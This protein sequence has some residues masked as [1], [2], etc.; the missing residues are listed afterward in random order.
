MINAF[1]ITWL[2][3]C[4]LPLSWIA[5]LW[6]PLSHF[7]SD[8]Q[9][10]LT[11]VTW[12]SCFIYCASSSFALPKKPLQKSPAF[13]SHLLYLSIPFPTPNVLFLITLSRSDS[14]ST[15]VCFAGTENSNSYEEV[16][17]SRFHFILVYVEVGERLP[18]L[19]L[20]PINHRHMLWETVIWYNNCSCKNYLSKVLVL[21]KFDM[22]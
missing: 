5:C 21:Y 2:R 11:D 20:V 17:G 8:P 7:I 19:N 9:L 15:K 12:I 10:L 14:Q 1:L 22:S 4:F 18:H 3:K 16:Y 13:L 6:N